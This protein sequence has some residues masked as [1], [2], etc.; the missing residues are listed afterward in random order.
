M[1]VVRGG[2]VPGIWAQ[3]YAY[4]RQGDAS[5]GKQLIVSGE[6]YR[7]SKM[8]PHHLFGMNQVIEPII[9]GGRNSPHNYPALFTVLEK[10]R[11]D[12][13]MTG[14]AHG[15]AAGQESTVLLEGISAA[16][17]LSNSATRLC[18]RRP[19]GIS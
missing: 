10:A 14:V 19:L 9:T 18:T 12:G 1:M 17:T 15:G 16:T 4:G 6:E 3:Q 8:G 2:M 11:A 13:G 7:D 5:N